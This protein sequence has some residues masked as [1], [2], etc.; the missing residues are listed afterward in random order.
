[1]LF[2]SEQGRLERLTLRGRRLVGRR[3][4]V[5][6]LPFGRH[7]QDPVAGRTRGR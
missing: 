1:M 5:K 2:V 3:V 6:G 7:Q 4:V